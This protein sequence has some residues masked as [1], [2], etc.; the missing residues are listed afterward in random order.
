VT[1][2]TS[3]ITITGSQ[4]ANGGEFVCFLLVPPVGHCNSLYLGSGKRQHWCYFQEDP[5][6]LGPLKYRYHVLHI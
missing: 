6:T 4:L 5:D 1:T 2:T 3:I